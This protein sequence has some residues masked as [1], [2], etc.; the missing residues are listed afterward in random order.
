MNFSVENYR[1][2]LILNGEDET[3]LE[4]V[5]EFLSQHPHLIVHTTFTCETKSEELLDIYREYREWLKVFK[6]DHNCEDSI[7]MLIQELEKN[8]I[9]ID[10]ILH[11]NEE[12]IEWRKA[13]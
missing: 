5:R 4:L 2:I 11:N 7:E 8:G 10:L 13:S 1:N 12:F 3:G 6:V 9:F